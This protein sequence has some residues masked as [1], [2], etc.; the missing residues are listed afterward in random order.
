VYGFIVLGIIP[1]TNIQIGFWPMMGLIAVSMAAFI[2]YKPRAARH[3]S[4]W[5]HHY[6]D[7]EDAPHRPLHANRLHRRMPKP[8]R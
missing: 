4:D 8:A 3:I 2:I 6:D 1:G 5:W 7:I